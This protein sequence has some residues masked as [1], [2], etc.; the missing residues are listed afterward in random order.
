VSL[1]GVLPF[2]YSA[3]LETQDAHYVHTSQQ[4]YSYC[5][6]YGTIDFIFG[7]A[8]AVFQN[9]TLLARLPIPGQVNTYTASGI[10]SPLVQKHA[11]QVFHSCKVDAAPDLV[12]NGSISQT[13]FLGRP[14]HQ[15]ARTVFIK[16]MLGGLVDPRGWTLWN[17]EPASASHVIY[18]E[19]S[20]FGPGSDHSLR[21]PWS[22]Q[23][24]ISEAQNYSVDNFLKGNRWLPTYNISFSSSI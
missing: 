24:T 3:L 4:F 19:Y 6:I 23:L 11:G 21:V 5:T 1:S 17:K 13:V 2:A 9:C 22:K 20:N 14:W 10:A 16:S 15:Y 12:K 18:G 8:A 7:S